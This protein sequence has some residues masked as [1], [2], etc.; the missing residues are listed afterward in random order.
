MRTI[1]AARSLD[2]ASSTEEVSREAQHHA[3][4]QGLSSCPPLRPG[5]ADRWQ[6]LALHRR[7]DSTG[8]GQTAARHSRTQTFQPFQSVEISVLSELQ[9]QGW[10]L[11]RSSWVAAVATFGL[12]PLRQRPLLNPVAPRTAPEL[13][14]RHGGRF[15]ADLAKSS[16]NRL[17]W[18]EPGR[19][20]SRTGM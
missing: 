9:G 3:G 4:R 11:I 19:I 1:R 13:R 14:L 15:A 12:G 5:I 7:S 10:V 2:R 6:G 17:L 16:W 18:A 8:P 20:T